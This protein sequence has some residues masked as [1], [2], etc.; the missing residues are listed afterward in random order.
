MNDKKELGNSFRR[1]KNHKFLYFN[2]LKVGKSLISD[3][4]PFVDAVLLGGLGNLLHVVP[5]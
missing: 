2:H 5:L 3:L 1:V 4:L